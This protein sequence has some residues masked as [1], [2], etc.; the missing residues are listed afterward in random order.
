MVDALPVHRAFHDSRDPKDRRKEAYHVHPRS[1]VSTVV[2]GQ[3][4]PVQEAF[5]K[6]RA[7]WAFV[8][9]RDGKLQRLGQ[10]WTAICGSEVSLEHSHT[11]SLHRASGS[12][13]AAR[14]EL[15]GRNRGRTRGLR[16]L[17]ESLPGPSQEKEACWPP[18]YSANER[19][20]KA[21]FAY[22]PFI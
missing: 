14:A 3:S 10:I 18:V 22:Y 2:Y 21:T 5:K 20:N 6:Q 7:E 13:Q 16:S 1:S 8:Y 4:W 17:W 12:S 9:S 15:G 19:G 11:P